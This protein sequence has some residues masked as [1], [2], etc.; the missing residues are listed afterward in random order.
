M[1]A[2]K[3]MKP[4]TLDRVVTGAIILMVMG[5]ILVL[6]GTCGGCKG[7]WDGQ[8][9]GMRATGMTEEDITEALARQ[10]GEI[11]EQIRG[12]KDAVID[13]VPVPAPKGPIKELTDYWLEAVLAAFGLG[14]AGY[15]RGQVVERKKVANGG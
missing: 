12:L 15:K 4:K 14:Y 1:E 3:V 6:V 5:A 9:E 7:Y 8:A 10:Q 2:W 13:A 11:A